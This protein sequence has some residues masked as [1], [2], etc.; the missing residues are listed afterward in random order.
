MRTTPRGFIPRN[1]ASPITKH[2]VATT[3]TAPLKRSLLKWPPLGDCCDSW[4]AHTHRHRIGTVRHSPGS[5]RRHDISH[6]TPAGNYPKYFWCRS[7]DVSVICRYV[8]FWPGIAGRNR[9]AAP[10]PAP[11]VTGF[12]RESSGA[13]TE[14]PRSGSR[15]M[16]AVCSGYRLSSPWGEAVALGCHGWC[17]RATSQPE[18][19]S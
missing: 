2:S 7:R 16:G 6:D 19:D 12:L 10:N 3:C 9:S 5:L 13:G 1:G 15:T 11:W 18:P 14:D 8:L 17:G 4:C